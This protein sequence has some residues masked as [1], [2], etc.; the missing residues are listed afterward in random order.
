MAAGEPL[1]VRF[2]ASLETISGFLAV[3]IAHDDG[4]RTEF[5]IPVP[6]YGVPEQRD[7]VLLRALVGNA[8]RFLRYVLALLDE[9][10]TR[11]TSSTRST[12]CAWARRTTAS[13]PQPPRARETAAD[14]AT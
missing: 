11:W 13:G 8:E 12:E 10:P 4:T 2:E 6:L 14:D 9:D 3:E 1:D 7:R 5:V